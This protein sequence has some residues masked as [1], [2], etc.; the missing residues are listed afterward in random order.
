MSFTANYEINQGIQTPTVITITDTSNY[1]ATP[2][3]NK[4]NFT[5]RNLELTLTDTLTPVVIP[6]PFDNSNN[7]I[8]DIITFTVDR[9]RAGVVKLVL[10]NPMPEPDSIFFREA[11]FCL[12]QFIENCKI[13][14]L[15]DLNLQLLKDQKKALSLMV[16]DIGEQSALVRASKGDI[17]ESQKDL[18]FTINYCKCSCCG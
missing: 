4:I 8:Q 15:A 2:N 13:N 10:T 16:V 14:K 7:L 1:G 12:T 11:T 6:F 3:T 18:D 5:S 9:D 17:I